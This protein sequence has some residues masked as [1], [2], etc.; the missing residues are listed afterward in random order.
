VS[1]DYYSVLNFGSR[2]PIFVPPAGFTDL[3]TPCPTCIVRPGEP[4]FY[5]F[6]T[7]TTASG[8]RVGFLRIPTMSPPSTAMALAQ[9]DRAMTVFGASTDGLI[10]DVMRNTF[11]EMRGRS[12]PVSLKATGS[13]SSSPWPLRTRSRS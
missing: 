11:N 6:G 8:V 3:N 5:L 7:F 13:C 9:L 12:A 4:L 10:V 2:F 1:K